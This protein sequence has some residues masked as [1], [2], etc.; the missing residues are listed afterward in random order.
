MKKFLCAALCA[1]TALSAIGCSGKKPSNSGSVGDDVYV[2]I[3]DA[4]LGDDWLNDVASAYYEET[5]IRVHVTA[6]TD[7]TA[8]LLQDMNTP[9]SEKDDMYFVG[10]QMNNWIKWTRNGLIASID[11]VLSSDKYG[12]PANER[13]ADSAILDMGKIGDKHYLTSYVYSSWGFVYNQNYLNRIESYGEY[14]KG[15]WPETVQGLLD[16][17]TATNNA[18]IVNNRTKQ[19]VKPFGCGFTVNYMNWLFQGLWNEIDPQ[20][21]NDYYNYNDKNGGFPTDKLVTTAT[22][23]AMETIYDL[24]DPKSSSD[25]NAVS[26]SQDHTESQQSFVNGDCVFAFTGSWFATEMRSIL[27][28]VGL[29][30]YHFGAY[31]VYNKGDKPTLMMNLPGETFVIPSEAVNVSGAKDFLAFVLSEKGVAAASR[32]LGFPM[33]YSTDQQ[34]TLSSFG[35][36]IVAVSQKANLAYV[37]SQN[38]VYRTGALELFLSEPKPILQIAKGASSKAAVESLLRQEAVHH[39]GLWSEYMKRI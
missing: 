3:I 16:L 8:S 35:Q 12:T 32:R 26:W 25:S 24:I 31:P 22:V 28:E 39:S 36:E 4:G 2:K 6:D 33:V 29:T 15:E 5:G 14:V 7:L 30:D 11:D 19:T 13:I 37:Y 20:G 18:K 10:Q 9:G 1:V 21:Y 38:D 27:S 17:C 34:V 23:K